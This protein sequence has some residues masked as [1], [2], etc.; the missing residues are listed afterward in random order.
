VVI[1]DVATP[2][3]VIDDADAPAIDNLPEG[4]EEESSNPESQEEPKNPVRTA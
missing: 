1:D 3:P 2:S 4:I